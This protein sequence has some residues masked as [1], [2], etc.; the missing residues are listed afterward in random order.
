MTLLALAPP[1][2]RLAL[3]APA[4]DRPWCDGSLRRLT[5]VA[6]QGDQVIA[7]S[8]RQ[9]L[10]HEWAGGERVEKLP[11]S[12]L[13]TALEPVMLACGGTWIAHGS[14][15]AD[16]SAVDARDGVS[17]R[18]GGGQYRLRRIWIDARQQRGHGDGFSNSGL[19][20]LCHHVQVRPV[21]DDDHWAAYRAV[22]QRFADAVV[23]EATQADPIV[24]V[25]DYHL[26][27]VPA[28]VRRRLPSATIVTFWHIPWAHVDQ[29]RI[30][31]WLDELVAGLAGSDV[32]GF[33]T[34]DDARYFAAAARR[35]GLTVDDAGNARTG[36]HQLRVRDYPISIAWPATPPQV[37]GADVADGADAAD[38]ADGAAARLQAR[39]PV[40]PQASA[41]IVGID[42]MDYTKGLLERVRAFEALLDAHPQWVGRVRLVQVAAPSRTALHEYAAFR[43]R[44]AGEVRRINAR[45]QAAGPAPIELREREHSRSEVQALYAQADVCLVTSLHD[46]MNLVCKEFIAARSDEQGVLVLSEF[47]GAAHELTDALIVNP[48]HPQRVA[49]ALHQALTM[50]AAEQR[51]RMRALRATVR[52]RN[53][54]R[55][56]AHLLRD[57]AALRTRAPALAA[58]AGKS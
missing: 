39:A 37:V 49:G 22:N 8:N 19:W 32:L 5:E 42:R 9:P 25:H 16:R 54:F 30:C 47:A 21:F 50:P 4:P 15:A 43:E 11:A 38:A 20:P 29:M 31:P 7:V 41:L 45:F 6:L 14:G 23:D 1:S 55:W 28:M 3:G 27:L 18:R 10:A 40:L 12:G 2:G 33:Q 58:L 34:P 26:A 13:V 35:S 46:G 44:L 48:Y 36:A 17:V 24:L 52:H 53:V 57:A 56:A 51:Q